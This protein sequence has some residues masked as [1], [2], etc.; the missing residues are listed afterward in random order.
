[1]D[2][3]QKPIERA[4]IVVINNN[5]CAELEELQSV[6]NG[7]V[8]RAIMALHGNHDQMMVLLAVQHWCIKELSIQL[9][10][11]MDQLE[12]GFCCQHETTNN[13]LC[14]LSIQ[15]AF[16]RTTI[17]QEGQDNSVSIGETHNNANQLLAPPMPKLIKA[18]KDLY[19]LWNKWTHGLNGSPPAKTLQWRSMEQTKW[20][21]V[22]AK[23]LGHCFLPCPNRRQ[24][25]L[26]STV[27][28][29][30]TVETILCWQSSKP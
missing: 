2:S 17:A 23:L 5:R 27:S 13:N 1:M 8:P 16:Q 21:S 6:F 22:A 30:C 10:S 4:S 24:C 18:P 20:R 11:R 26:P 28:M 29:T 25:M 14:C 15:S 12:I 7:A 9:L 3:R 19:I